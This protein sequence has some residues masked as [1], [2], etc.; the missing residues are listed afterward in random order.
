MAAESMNSPKDEALLIVNADDYGYFESVSL[1]IL[2]GVRDGVITATGVLANCRGFEKQV[3]ELSRLPE[4]DVGVHLTLTSGRPLTERMRGLMKVWG[5]EFP[6]SKVWAA[7]AVLSGRIGMPAVEEEWG[8]QIQRCLDA[9]LVVRFLNS[10]EHLHVLPPL[11]GLCVRLACRYDIPHIRMPSAE[12]GSMRAGGSCVR[13]LVLAGFHFWNAR[14]TAS[15]APV[16]LGVG[17]S[18]KLNLDYLER[19][20]PTLR[21]GEVYE[22]MCHP[23]RLPRGEIEDVRLLAY[24]DWSGELQALSSEG[25]KALCRNHGVRLARFRDVLA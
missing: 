13:N 17:V 3:S 23:G 20:I 18:G 22:L 7:W 10:H 19:L 5:G 1:G 11:F 15:R 4:L 12:W 16:L 6:R 9:G 8:R 25:F 21:K 14:R 2:D 24:H